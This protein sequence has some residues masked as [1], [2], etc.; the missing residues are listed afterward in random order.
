MLKG[1]NVP[2]PDSHPQLQSS[3]GLASGPSLEAG[4]N[5]APPAHG[6]GSLPPEEDPQ[7]AEV[8]SEDTLQHRQ[9]RLHDVVSL[10]FF[11]NPRQ[12]VYPVVTLA[13]SCAQRHGQAARNFTTAS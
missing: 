2:L 8:H 1:C 9:E 12:C 11:L 6:L 4:S 13:C 3:P 10:Y 7:D 5:C